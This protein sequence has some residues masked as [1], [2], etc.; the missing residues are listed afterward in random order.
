MD[1]YWEILTLKYVQSSRLRFWMREY[2][3]ETDV[4][5][6]NSPSFPQPCSMS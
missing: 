5:L 1:K 2:E 3:D 4:D 6:S